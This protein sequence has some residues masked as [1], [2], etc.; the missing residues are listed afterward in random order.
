[1]NTLTIDGI[2]LT[3][4]VAAELLALSPGEPMSM[5]D[6]DPSYTSARMSRCVLRAARLV[7][8]EV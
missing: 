8:T 2:V 4:T 3:Q 5:S 1:M 6:D 7:G